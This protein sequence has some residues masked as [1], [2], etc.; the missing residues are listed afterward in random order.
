LQLYV[1]YTVP[2]AELDELAAA[3]RSM[4]AQLTAAHPGLACALLRRPELKPAGVTLMETYAGPPL[5]EDFVAALQAAAQHLP[6][7][8]HVERFEPLR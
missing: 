7:P 2:E 5:G 8:R 3:V 6:Q 4:Q 1:Y